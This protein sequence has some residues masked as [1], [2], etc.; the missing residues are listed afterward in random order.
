MTSTPPETDTEK[1]VAINVPLPLELHQ[2]LRIR[3]I[4]E[5]ITMREAVIAAIDEWSA[6]V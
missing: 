4:T 2:R 1:T 5:N 6:D 3:A